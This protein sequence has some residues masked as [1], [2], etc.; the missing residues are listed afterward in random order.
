MSQEPATS[1][2]SEIVDEILGDLDEGEIHVFYW[3][4]GEIRERF[5]ASD[6]FDSNDPKFSELAEN[7]ASRVL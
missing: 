4:M 3:L 2:I 6:Q 5:G 7:L 1:E